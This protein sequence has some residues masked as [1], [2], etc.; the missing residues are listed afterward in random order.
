MGLM[1]LLSMRRRSLDRITLPLV[2]SSIT[3]MRPV[4]QSLAARLGWDAAA[5]NRLMLACEEAVLFLLEQRA[6]SG[7]DLAQTRERVHLRFTAVDGD[8]EVELVCAPS[9]VNVQAAV[10]ALPETS[11]ADP[12]TDLSLRLLRAMTR[13]I[14]H[15][16]YHG[17][18]YLMLRVDSRG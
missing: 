12:E 10:A 4:V 14:R 7:A 11:E 9:D 18:D 2:P 8:A 6:A 1:A 5:E 17:V 13:D 16:Q 3:S 15:R